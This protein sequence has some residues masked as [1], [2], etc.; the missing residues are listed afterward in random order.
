MK[1]GSEILGIDFK[2]DN[3]LDAY[4]FASILQRYLMIREHQECWDMLGD[5]YKRA[6]VD[7][8]KRK[9]RKIKPSDI[10][11]DTFKCVLKNLTTR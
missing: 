2:N 8:R 9:M 4:M 10:G 7:E 11:K 1:Y 3:V 5:S 6:F